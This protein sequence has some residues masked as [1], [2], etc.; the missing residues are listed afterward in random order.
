MT[1]SFP[2]TL[3]RAAL[4]GIGAA[5]VFV[6]VFKLSR[7]KRRPDPREQAQQEEV[8]VDER[9]E[10]E[11]QLVEQSRDD[12]RPAACVY[13][14]AA[15]CPRIEEEQQQLKQ[16]MEREPSDVAL[17]SGALA[18]PE[19]VQQPPA[20]ADA[21]L[22]FIGSDTSG[23]CPCMDQLAAL[24]PTG[25]GSEEEQH[26]QLNRE[27]GRYDSFDAAPVSNLQREP[28]RVQQP[29]QTAE[30]VFIGPSPACC[31]AGAGSEEQQQLKPEL[32]RQDAAPV[33]SLQTLSEEE[34]YQQPRSESFFIGSD[35]IGSDNEVL[36]SLQR[37]VQPQLFHIGSDLHE[38]AGSSSGTDGMTDTSEVASR[39]PAPQKN[40]AAQEAAARIQRWYRKRAHSWRVASTRRVES[41]TKFESDTKEE[42]TPSARPCI[43]ED[44][45]KRDAP[46][47]VVHDVHDAQQALQTALNLVLAQ[48]DFKDP[49]KELTTTDTKQGQALNQ[50]VEAILNSTDAK[51]GHMVRPVVPNRPISDVKTESAQKAGGQSCGGNLAMELHMEE[52]EKEAEP[53][54]FSAIAAQM[55]YTLEQLTNPKIWRELQVNPTEREN[56]LPDSTFRDLFRMDKE[57]FRVL[58]KWKRDIQKKKLGLF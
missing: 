18:K 10:E 31:L 35:T 58:P 50:A 36:A 42:T 2:T 3:P 41:G 33:S 11:S 17:V 12:T 32:E 51:T 37:Q 4:L 29:P 30:Q 39:P 15:C 48:D 5:A 8:V 21:E 14:E 28:D 34:V 13:G 24:C 53:A 54:K 23:P 52:P 27:F 55:E 44:I 45:S 26:R 19:E 1:N 9:G 57:A 38:A 47:A 22:F 49:V 6:V 43:A 25:S 46:A 7:R 56:L 16:G 40:P 20:S